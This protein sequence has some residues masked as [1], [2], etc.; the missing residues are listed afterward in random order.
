MTETIY[1]AAFERQILLRDAYRIS[2]QMIRECLTRGDI[3][4]SEFLYVYFGL[5]ADRRS[6]D[7]AALDDFLAAE[8]VVLGP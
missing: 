2:E 8:A 1:D 3:P 6:A 7:P 5:G 4:L